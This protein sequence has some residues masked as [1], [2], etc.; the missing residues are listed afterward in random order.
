MSVRRVILLYAFTPYEF[1][2]KGLIA[3]KTAR[4]WNDYWTTLL[5]TDELY[6]HISKS[7]EYMYRPRT[8]KVPTQFYTKAFKNLLCQSS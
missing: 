1:V 6:E 7:C 3:E 4:R 8:I 2:R 5:F